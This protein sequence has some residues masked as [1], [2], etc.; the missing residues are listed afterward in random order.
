MYH[1]RFIFLPL[2]VLAVSSGT[3]DASAQTCFRGCIAQRVKG[4][5]IT[6]DMIRFQMTTCRDDCEEESRAKRAS[7]GI[8]RTLEDCD[9]QPVTDAEFKA[10]RSASASFLVYAHAFTWDVHNILTGKIIRKV[11]I[12]YPTMDLDETIATGGGTVLPGETQTILINGVFDGYPA[13]HYALKVR[14]VYACP[15]D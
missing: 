5:D 11:E 10:L 8:G 4:A 7:L 13:M 15:S 3:G 12:S 14:A 1:A 2:A 9:P 6:D